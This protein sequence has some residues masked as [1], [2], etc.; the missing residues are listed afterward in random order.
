MAGT[1]AATLGAAI[2]GTTVE[3]PPVGP[4]LCP[5]R[6]TTGLPCPFCGLT[7]SLLATGQGAWRLS[8]DHHAL[9]P[10]VLVAAAVLLPLSVRAVVRLKP[11]GWPRFTLGT[12]SLVLMMGWAVNLASGGP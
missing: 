2:L 8:I 1:C 7:H 4:V 10:L 11:L 6:L 3:N 9:G 12:L 5:F